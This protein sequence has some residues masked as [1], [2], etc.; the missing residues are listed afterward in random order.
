MTDFLTRAPHV[1]VGFALG[2][3]NVVVFYVELCETFLQAPEQRGCRVAVNKK[4]W[5][6]CAV[7]VDGG[8]LIDEPW[9]AI[10]R[11]LACF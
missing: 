4:V 6:L 11:R 7:C 5:Y 3:Q 1:V 9:E 10:T 8:T 2:L